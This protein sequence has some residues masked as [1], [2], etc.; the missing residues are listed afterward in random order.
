M[1]T[2]KL[3]QTGKD[4]AVR[5]PPEFRFKGEEVFIRKVPGG[6]LLISEDE[7]AWDEWAKR[8]L[9]HE[10]PFDIERNQPAAPEVRDELDELFP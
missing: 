8:I 9:E 3:F 1:K 7:A 5:L 10:A 4:Q 2:A 6:V